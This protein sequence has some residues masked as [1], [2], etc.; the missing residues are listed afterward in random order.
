MVFGA[1]GA[2]SNRINSKFEQVQTSITSFMVCEQAS[3]SIKSISSYMTERAQLYVMTHELKYAEDYIHEKFINKGRENAIL[4]L[5]EVSN[6]NDVGYQRLQIAMEQSESLSSLEVYAMRLA[7]EAAGEQKLPRQLAEIEIRPT[8]YRDNSMEW[9]ELAQQ[10]IFGEGYLIYKTRVNG[11]CLT[12]ITEIEKDVKDQI[13]EQQKSLQ[14]YLSLSNFLNI[15]LVVVF[16]LFFFILIMLVL[17][18]LKS[19][20]QSIKNKERLNVMG[21]S[22]MVYLAETY[23]DVHEY[24]ALTKILNR[25]AFSEIC[26]RSEQDGE[27]VAF[28]L[29]DLDD[30]KMVND[31]YG[32]AKGDEVLQTVAKYLKLAFRKD[33]YVARI[34]GD[35]FAVI[36]PNFTKEYSVTA[37]EKIRSVNDKLASLSG[38]EK[39]SLSAG[40]AFSRKGYSKQLYENADRALYN[41]KNSGKKGVAVWD[42]VL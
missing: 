20:V 32:H 30:F 3:E 14:R 23:N 10:T 40:I 12:T 5:M 27:A 25:R 39:I 33:D 31:T 37:V 2:I 16:A 15:A 4:R 7:A 22:E 28:M 18:P 19:F 8:D 9:Q 1:L 21:S 36:I 34:G 26:E 35:E 29:V 11:N 6:P 17:R 38:Y 13:V 24:D 41:V 42:E